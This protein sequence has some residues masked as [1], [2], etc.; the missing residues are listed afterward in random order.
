MFEGAQHSLAFTDDKDL[1]LF[2][3]GVLFVDADYHEAWAASSRA[4]RRSPIR[5]SF[6]RRGG[7]TRQQAR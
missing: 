6:H 5:C 4:R 1:E 7:P 3:C 2:T